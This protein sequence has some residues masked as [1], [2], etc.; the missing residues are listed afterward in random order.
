VPSIESRARRFAALGDPRRLAIAESLVASHRTPGELI[1][2]TGLSSSLLAH[3]LDIL[4]TADVI[5]RRDGTSDKRKRFIALH[6]DARALMQPVK[7]RGPVLFVCTHNSARSQ[8]ASA[9][10]HAET[11][12][13]ADSAGTHPA[14]A[15]HPL[16]VAVAADHGLDLTGTS[17]RLINP[18][19]L[20]RSTVI[21]V[22]DQAHDEIPH[23]LD[24]FHWS[25]PDPVTSGK[26]RDFEQVFD[27]LSSIIN[28]LKG[29]NHVQ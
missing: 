16:A 17:P 14:K 6:D 7:L 2:L 11:G 3:H 27:Q 13:L 29:N 8:L 24:R 28:Q 19:E 21:T 12:E 1:E 4:E 20:H 25:I 26:S 23:P 5:I 10:W 22:C 18:S 9:I 15:V